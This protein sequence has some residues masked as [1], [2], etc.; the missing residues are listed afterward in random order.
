MEYESGPERKYKTPE[1]MDKRCVEYFEWVKQGDEDDK[2][3][4]TVTGLIIFLKLSK[5][6]FY[7]YKER[8]GYKEILAR[9]SMMVENGYEMELRSRNVTGS[10]FALKQFGWTDRQDINQSI[11]VQSL[12][13]ISLDGSEMRFDIGKVSDAEA[14]LIEHKGNDDER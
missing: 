3:Y 4:P 10:I 2:R 1:L 12:P 5:A 11:V 13:S 8:V 7:V 6:T 9:A 14:K